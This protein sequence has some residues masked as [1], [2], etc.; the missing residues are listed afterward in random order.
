MNKAAAPPALRPS[1][2]PSIE[3]PAPEALERYR[4]YD[5]LNAPYIAWQVEQFRP[6]LGRR[7]LEIGC[8]AGSVIAQLPECELV[9]GIDS[10]PAAVQHCAER[11]RSRAECRFETLDISQAARGQLDEL[12]ALRFDTIL[13]I[14]VLEHIADDARALQAMEHVLEP[15][16]RLG[17]LVPAHPALYGPY[18]RLDGHLR[19]YTKRSLRAALAQT[20]LRLVRLRRFNALGALGWWLHYRLLRRTA[21]GG[22]QFRLMN[23]CVPL[24]RRAERIVP[25]PFGLSLV[26]VLDAGHSG[27]WAQA[28]LERISASSTARCS[29]AER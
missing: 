14:N 10:D 20:S 2:D 22:R 26:A 23:A 21:H 17:L 11:F 5:R 25:P 3:A 13:C 29:R 8:G 16:G 24:L 18:D 19:R 6:F 12:R 4:A 7:I 9:Y 28:P 1:A 27:A 15:R